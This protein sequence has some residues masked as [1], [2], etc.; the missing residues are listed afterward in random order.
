[1]KILGGIPWLAST[2]IALSACAGNGSNGS[3]GSNARSPFPIAPS[4]SGGAANAQPAT[5]HA[6]SRDSFLARYANSGISA[7]VKVGGKDVSTVRSPMTFTVSAQGDVTYDASVAPQTGGDQC[8]TTNA[9]ETS[10]PLGL[11]GTFRLPR[12]TFEKL[13]AAATETNVDELNA[14]RSHGCIEYSC[15]NTSERATIRGG[16][17]NEQSFS[18]FMYLPPNTAIV[19]ELNQVSEEVYRRVKGNQGT[20][21]PLAEVHA[22]WARAQE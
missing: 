22:A 10:R 6:T 15:P 4:G 2:A 14:K 3:G 21:V 20:A 7:S 11:H 19:T 12:S 8:G 17:S 1:M 16:A 5:T 18:E 9:S 13:R